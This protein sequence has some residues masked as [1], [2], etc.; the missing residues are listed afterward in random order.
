VAT[1][2]PPLSPKEVE[3]L[4]LL[5][6]GLTREDVAYR[7]AIRRGTLDAHLGSIYLKLDAANITQAAAI[8]GRRRGR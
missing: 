4:D 8:W 3:V 6:A 5:C 7:L 2:Q 1:R